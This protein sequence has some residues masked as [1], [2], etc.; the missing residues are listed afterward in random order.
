MMRR[1]EAE[2]Q[3]GIRRDFVAEEFVAEGDQRSL[4]CVSVSLCLGV[5]YL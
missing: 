1:R 3:R 4:L 2:T 5:Q